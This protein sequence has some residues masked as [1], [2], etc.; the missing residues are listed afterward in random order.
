MKD[1]SQ[2]IELPIKVDVSGL[3]HQEREQFQKK[4]FE[5]GVRWADGS[6]DIETCSDF[7]FISGGKLLTH[8]SNNKRSH[9]E[10]QHYTEIKVQQLQEILGMKP[11][12]FT[13]ADLKDGMVVRTRTDKYAHT[14]L[15]LG[16][17]LVAAKSHLELAEYN[18]DL[19]DTDDK[20]WDIVEVL[21]L[22]AP[23][24]SLQIENWELKS[25][26]KREEKSAAQLEI[27]QI[28]KQVDE[29]NT[30][31]ETLKGCVIKRA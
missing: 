1:L 6:R 20:M 30:R 14:Y 4:L 3:T 12:Q 19:T 21:E 5:H 9:F 15:V 28:Q 25:I 7:N 23:A 18:E 22:A 27:E 11:K 10:G 24:N 26:W 8:V 31:L 13:K 16:S 17:R 29:L 2:L